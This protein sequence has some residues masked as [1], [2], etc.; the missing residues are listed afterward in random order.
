VSK[1]ASTVRNEQLDML[2]G[3]AILL[4]IWRHIVE[5]PA[6]FPPIAA[7]PLMFL[8][9]IGW[10][11]VD[12]FF[13]LSGFLVSGLVIKE[14]KENGAFQP[15][16]FLIRRGFKIYPSYY[17]LVLVTLLLLPK[18][19]LDANSWKFIACVFVFVQ[20]Y[21]LGLLNTFTN[22]LLVHT[23]SLAVEE[24]FYFGLTLIS[25]LLLRY[26]KSLRHLPII[27]L[28][29]C[30]LAL[31]ARIVTVSYFRS[32]ANLAFF[33]T[34]L[35]ID[36]LSFGVFLAYVY[37]NHSEWLEKTVRERAVPLSILAIACIMPCVVW[38]VSTDLAYTVGLT[39]LYLGFGLAMMLVIHKPLS[40]PP[41]KAIAYVGFYSY[42]IYLWHR[43]ILLLTEA[44]ALLTKMWYPLVLV[45]Y[46]VLSIGVG[47]ACAKTIELPFL[48]LRNRL[49]PSRTKGALP[50]DT[51]AS[52]KS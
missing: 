9:N 49:F 41:L 20:N 16:R 23:W 19:A 32:S 35:R 45:L 46:F 18:Q 1:T 25:V 10:M 37:H 29:V 13:V 2:R 48:S 36:G 44:T 5:P 31:I 42:S 52:V 6:W 26:S 34:H 27:C 38:G 40:A 43:I 33:E 4:V 3:I 47:I 11:G 22:S 28:S 8:K 17:I 12:L 7:L 21:N 15:L 50:P 30:A 24:H 14:C 39:L 51:M